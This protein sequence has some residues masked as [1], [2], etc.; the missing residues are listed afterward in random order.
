MCLLLLAVF[1][2]AVG[3]PVCDCV[4]LFLVAL[5]VLFLLFVLMLLVVLCFSHVWCYV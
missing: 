5:S 2:V 1:V 4:F 3:F